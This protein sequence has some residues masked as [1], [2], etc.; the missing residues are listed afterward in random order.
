MA[1]IGVRPI[2][3]WGFLPNW[4]E[5]RNLNLSRFGMKFNSSSRLF[6]RR[7]AWG[8][9]PVATRNTRENERHG[10]PWKG[11]TLVLFL[12]KAGKSIGL[13][14]FQ[15]YFEGDSMYVPWP[16]V[17]TEYGC[18]LQAYFNLNNSWE[19]C[20][21][22]GGLVGARSVWCESWTVGPWICLICSS[23]SFFFIQGP[24]E[25]VSHLVILNMA[26]GCP[27][28]SHSL[29]VVSRIP[30]GSYDLPFEREDEIWTNHPKQWHAERHVWVSFS[31]GHLGLCCQ[32]FFS[33]QPGK[34]CA[35]RP[36]FS[37]NVSNWVFQSNW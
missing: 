37:Q 23:T 3:V 36:I 25:V 16:V 30:E 10:G 18:N 1:K 15:H 35:H 28:A 26:I 12:F 24:K 7:C 11:G 33:S 31:L 13:A 20:K 22:V 5:G 9:G 32:T 4:G 27:T 6:K 19:F 34:A 21:D 8:L 29:N 2:A 17:G 14:D